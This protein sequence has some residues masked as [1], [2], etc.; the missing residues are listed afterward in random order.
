MFSVNLYFTGRT[1]PP[2][3]AG[4]MP[5]RNP[6]C[7]AVAHAESWNSTYQMYGAGLPVTYPESED[8]T[9]FQDK[10]GN[11]HLFTNVNTGHQRCG[12][13]VPC[14]GHAW[15]RDGYHFSDLV[16]GA[17]GPVVTFKNGT[18]WRNAYVERPL[19]TMGADRV[20]PLAFFVGLGRSSYTDS[21]NWPQL[22]CTDGTDPMCG[23]TRSALSPPPKL[24]NG[25]KCLI[26]ANASSFPCSGSGDAESCPVVMGDCTEPSSQWLFD[27]RSRALLSATVK[28][29]GGRPVGINVDCDQSHPHTLVKALASSFTSVAVAG[30]TLSVFGGAACLNTG[31]GAARPLCGPSTE[32]WLPNQIQL[33]PCSDPSA[34]G[35]E[36]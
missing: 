13:G 23:P 10:R 29:S 11:F 15:S 16:I 3:P 36:F 31:Q 27:P 6:T 1:C 21:C 28:S 25:G 32:R 2:A 14:G 8:P 20:T 26:I 35:W 18:E 34:H 22:V 19:F 7:I 4:R 12:V 17:F 33:V 5:W 30:D 24:R 9:V